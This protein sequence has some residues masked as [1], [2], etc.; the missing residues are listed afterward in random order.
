MTQEFYKFDAK[1]SY[2]RSPVTI[3]ADIE[4]D[5]LAHIDKSSEL[6]KKNSFKVIKGK[7]WLDILPFN[8]STHFAISDR[9]KKIID[10]NILT[11]LMTF[12][13]SIV[14]HK[15]KNY[16]G[17]IITSSAGAIQNLEK[18]N[19]YEEENIKFDFETWDGS[20]FFTLKDTLIFACTK[21]V[22]ELLTK[23]KLTNL[24]V[25]KL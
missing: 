6:L 22:A 5:T 10:D 24:E 9:L 15:E 1:I 2:G 13:I 8:N 18:L 25:E 23:H 20:D 14:G 4:F 12:P 19:N 3:E 7:K 21:E 11:G 16:Y 17:L